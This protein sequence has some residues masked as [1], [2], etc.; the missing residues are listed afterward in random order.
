MPPASVATANVAIPNFF[1]DE[2]MITPLLVLFPLFVAH[3]WKAPEGGNVP[4]T[5]Y[6]IT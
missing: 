4:L 2:R 3:Y 6:K 5:L 1:K